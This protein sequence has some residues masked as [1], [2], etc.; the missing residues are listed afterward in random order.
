MEEGLRKCHLAEAEHLKVEHRSEMEE[1]RTHQQEQVGERHHGS[2]SF[3]GF[4]VKSEQERRHFPWLWSC[5]VEEMTVHHRAAV[6]E[7]RDMHN[8][9][10]ATLHEEHA[11]TMRG[12]ISVVS[13]RNAATSVVIMMMI[14]HEVVLPCLDLRKAH[15]QQKLLLEEDFEKLRLSLQ[16]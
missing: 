14:L 11:R 8:I 13:E 4:G 5:Q 9:T 2:H 12:I 10:M 7:L 3:S 15:E 1:L 16:V 6:Q